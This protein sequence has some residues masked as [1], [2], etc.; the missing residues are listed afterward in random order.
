MNPPST[1]RMSATTT[2][3]GSA[4]IPASSRG[5]TRYFIGLV[6]SVRQR[7]DLV[8]YPHGADFGGHRGADAAGDHQSGQHRPQFAGDRQHHQVG[9]RALGGEPGKPGIGLQRQHHAGEHRGQRHDRQAEIADLQQGAGEQASVEGRPDEAGQPLQ[10]EQR[11]GSGRA[12][13]ADDRAADGGQEVQDWR[14]AV[15]YT[16]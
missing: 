5:A 10:R 3:S 14:H 12:A 11:Q 8:G 6:D 2:S 15:R 7:V 13:Q 4:M 9:D 16:R 1:P